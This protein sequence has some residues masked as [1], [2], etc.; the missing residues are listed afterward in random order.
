MISNFVFTLLLVGSLFATFS[1]FIRAFF[2][3]EECDEFGGAKAFETIYLGLLFV[4][5]LMSITKPIEK[6]NIAYTAL[7]LIFGVFIFVSI[8][9]GFS[10]FWEE[11]E[12]VAVAYILLVTMVMSYLV[13]P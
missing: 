11:A 13:P 12:N 7:V 2:D 1:I 6:S 3:S 4:F 9:F 8:G 5:I 10:Y